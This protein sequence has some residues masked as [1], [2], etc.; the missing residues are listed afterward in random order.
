M[1]DISIT[2]GTVSKI[3]GTQATGVAGVTVKGGDA[4]YI[5]TSDSNKIKLADNGA[6]AT[7]VVAGIVLNHTSFAAQPV[8]YQTNGVIDIGGTVVVAEPYFLTTAGGIGVE[9]DVASAD[10]TTFIGV[11]KTGAANIAMAIFSSETVKP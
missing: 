1:A 6:Q 11:G 8:T 9:T 4:I 7:S 5:D 3:S 10:F 2:Q